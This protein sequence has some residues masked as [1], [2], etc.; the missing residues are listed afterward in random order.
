MSLNELQVEF[1]RTMA[2]FQVWCCEAG[3]QIIEAE[4][5][6]TP[7]QAKLYKEQGKGILNSTHCKKLARDLF[8]YKN[9]TVTWD[10]ADYQEIGEKWK[11]MHPLARWGGDFARRDAV[12][13]SFEYQGVK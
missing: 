5:Y 2:Y 12:H 11:T 6:R 8:L 3:H 7:E 13:F 10:K 4:S 9:N 1:T